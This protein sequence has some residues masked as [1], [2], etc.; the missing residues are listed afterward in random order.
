MENLQMLEQRIIV[1]TSEGQPVYLLAV[2]KNPTYIRLSPTSY[3]LLKQRSLGTSFTSLATELS[4]SEKQFSPDEVEAAYDRV[5]DKITEIERNPKLNRSA[6]LWRRTLISQKVVQIIARYLSVAFSKPIAYS[7]LG[8]IG[9]SIAI[10]P[11]HDALFSTHSSDWLWGYFL[12]LISLIFHEFGHASACARYGAEPSDIGFTLYLIWPAFYSDVSAA[13]QLKRWQRVVVDV[14]G[15]FF[16]LIAAAIYIIIYRFTGWMPLK[17]GL[18]LIAASC[19]LTLNPVFKFDGYWV[20]ADALGVTNLSQQPVKIFQHCVDKLR[21]RPVKPLPWSPLIISILAIYMLVSFGVWGYF[22]GII[23]LIFGNTISQYPA[24]VKE[25]TIQISIS[26]LAIDGKLLQ[27][28][29]GSTFMITIMG[30][31]LWKCWQVIKTRKVKARSSD[32]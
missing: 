15:V 14:G 26:P 1:D 27:S 22:F 4:Q 9:F 2:G 20:V 23:I 29:L 19:F 25:L 8:L 17:I 11:Q 6:F 16:Q 24:L 30:F 3:Y 13:W 18:L 21:R 28:F 5:I 10:A 32:L 12:F 7:L 31:M